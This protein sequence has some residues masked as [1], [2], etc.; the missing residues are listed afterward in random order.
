M[1]TKNIRTPED[2]SQVISTLLLTDKDM[3]MLSFV[4]FIRSKLSVLQPK[5]EWV[6]NSARPVSISLTASGAGADW[7][8]VNDISA[9]P[10][11]STLIAQLRVGDVLILPTGDEA[12]VVKSIDLSGNTIDLYARGHGST[13]ATA[14]GIAAFTTKIVGNA[15]IENAD[16][17]LSN[18]VAQT[19]L[20][21]YT[22]I[23]EDV[24]QVTGSM[25]RS[26]QLSG[27]EL[28]RQIVKKLKELLVSL[29]YSLVEGIMEYDAT[30]N[31]R[32]M[33]G[34]REFLSTTY[35]VNGALTLAKLFSAVEAHLNAGGTPTQLHAS[36]T[37][38]SKISQLFTGQVNYLPSDGKVGINVQKINIMGLTLELYPDRHVRSG[39]FILI[40]R[41]RVS[42]GPLSGGVENGKFQ[43][44][45]LLDKKNGKQN[46]VQ[47]LGEY[48]CEVRNLAG[49]GV[50][51]Y[52]IT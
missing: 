28:N 1:L 11:S 29:N 2:L 51:A 42:Y 19:P 33:G 7:D 6:D 48:T 30:N 31:F 23:F 17:L 41:D 52:G 14:Q 16:P 45:P 50:R 25:Q 8:S 37:S 15:Q 3:R 22:Q 4:N 44:Y 39:E 10:V 21:N 5:H 40:D 49:A 20:F 38:V 27:N 26:K 24:I 32:T 12:V 46:A 43:S 13:P 18:F 9:L 47:L 35:N 34:L 36:I